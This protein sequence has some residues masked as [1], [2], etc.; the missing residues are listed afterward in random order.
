MLYLYC[1]SAGLISDP[2][3]QFR[4]RTRTD[5]VFQLIEEFFRVNHDNL[6]SCNF[7]LGSYTLFFRSEDLR[8][9]IVTAAIKF[10]KNAAG[11]AFKVIEHQENPASEA[12]EDWTGYYLVRQPS[13]ARKSTRFW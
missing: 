6:G 12:V 13:T 10:E 3:I 1:V 11:D 7:M 2:T 4:N 8:N 9:H 5:P